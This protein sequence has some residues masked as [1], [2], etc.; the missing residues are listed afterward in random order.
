MGSKWRS[1]GV[2]PAPDASWGL[3]GTLDGSALEGFD[4]C[5]RRV[6]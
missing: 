4:L 3:G 2:E 5:A 1:V 6:K